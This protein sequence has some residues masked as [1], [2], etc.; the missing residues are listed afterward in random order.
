MNVVI[1]RGKCRGGW[2]ADGTSNSP[3]LFDLCGGRGREERSQ[4]CVHGIDVTSFEGGKDEGVE[5]LSD[6][7]AGEGSHVFFAKVRDGEG[8]KGHEPISFLVGKDRR[9]E[10]VGGEHFL[11][12]ELKENLGFAR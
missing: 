5:V 9:E 11:K 6:L 12:A 7:W 3:R 2:L 10:D 1:D 8:G 4:I